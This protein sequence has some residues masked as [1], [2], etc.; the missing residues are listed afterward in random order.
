MRRFALPTTEAKIRDAARF[1]FLERF[2]YQVRQAYLNFL[3][4]CLFLISFLPL[5]AGS[6]SSLGSSGN[7][8]KQQSCSGNLSELEKSYAG[9]YLSPCSAEAHN[10]LGM[11]LGE[12]GHLDAAL[13]ELQTATRLKPD[14]AQAFYNLG[15]TYLKKA[16]LLRDHHSATYRQELVYALQAFRKVLQLQP[17]LPGIHTHLGMLYEEIGSH[18]VAVQEFR[19]AVKSDP[20]P[21]LAYNNLGTALANDRRFKDAVQ[22]FRK[23]LDLNPH[24]VTAGLNLGD[25]MLQTGGISS[26]VNEWESAIN[27]NP[28]SAIAH[29]YFGY[30]LTF[31][32]KSSKAVAELEEAVR[33][34]PNLAIAHFY[35]GQ[36]LEKLGDLDRSEKHLREA[37]RLSPVTNAFQVELG[38]V[39][40]KENKVWEAVALL[41]KAVA[42]NPGNIQ[43]Q[44]TLARALR[45]VGD[46]AAAG[47]HFQEASTLS[48]KE[49]NLGAAQVQILEGARDLKRGKVDQAIAELREATA[50]EPDLPDASYY[51]GIALA[52]KGDTGEA[53]QAFQ[54]ALSG[55]PANPEIHYNFGIA[56]WHAGKAAAA[57]RE[58]RQAIQFKPD[59]GLAH[60][61]LGKA[62]KHEGQVLEGQDELR[63]AAQFGACET[64]SH[65]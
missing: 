9:M 31:D 33:L 15:V 3:L 13:A 42:K 40:Q 55:K 44:Y 48:E 29:T 59:Y 17:G 6:I 24:F 14:Y 22:A 62:L 54:N 60:C 50:M 28:R 51:L 63:R 38:V 32:N 58:F 7:G 64:A 39:F 18:E 36:I 61:A 4:I 37:V 35:L 11:S 56:L 19:E 30:A 26:V 47:R 10:N 57:I 2:S 49:N 52:E 16:N 20:N 43:A 34:D 65:H 5:D 12:S 53:I 8:S 27:R 21:A 41:R 45:A 23:S 1:A 46:T 25:A